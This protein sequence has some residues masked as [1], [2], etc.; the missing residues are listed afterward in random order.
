M[1]GTAMKK[2]VNLKAVAAIVLGVCAVAA[3]GIGAAVNSA[4]QK[5]LQAQAEAAALAEAAHQ[6]AV[7]AAAMAY[8]EEEAVFSDLVADGQVICALNASDLSQT[9]HQQWEEEQAA[10]A[11]MGATTWA[12][13]TGKF[14]AAAYTGST[15]AGNIGYWKR[16]NDD[17]I[18]WLRVPGTN[19]DYPIVQNLYDVN[20]YTKK[21]YDKQYSFNGVIWTNPGTKT[22]DSPSGLSPNTVIYGHNWTNYG[23]SPRIGNPKDIVFAQLNTYHWLSVA[24]SYPYFYYSTAEG[25]QFTVKIFAVFY[26][27]LAFAYNGPGGNIPYIIEEARRRSRFTF[28]VDVDSS[29]KLVTLSTCTRAYGPTSNQRFVVMGRLLRPGEKIE[30]VDIAY[31][32]NH[33]QP[34]V[35]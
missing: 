32:P 8:R 5:A 27:E 7:A 33:K 18:G 28:D 20:Y 2:P 22:S 13:P 21:G 25:G 34:S 24:Q 26:T 30:P 29:D 6:E 35:W 16:Q 12:M 14:N 23:G 17:V 1:E 31:N 19:I 15:G 9:Y 3:V 4:R 10:V 11:A